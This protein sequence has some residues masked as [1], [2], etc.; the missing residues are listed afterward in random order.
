MYCVRCGDLAASHYVRLDTS[1]HVCVAC[2]IEE[3]H[4]MRERVAVL[5]ETAEARDAMKVPNAS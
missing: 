1:G 4:D 3:V 5:E 2:L